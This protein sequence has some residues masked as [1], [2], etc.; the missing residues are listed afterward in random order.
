MDTG[1]LIALCA[2]W[3]VVAVALAADLLGR[4]PRSVPFRWMAAGLP[5]MLGAGR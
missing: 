2:G 3:L 4:R 1:T 5:V